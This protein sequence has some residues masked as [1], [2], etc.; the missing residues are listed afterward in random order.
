MLLHTKFP[1]FCFRFTLISQPAHHATNCAFNHRCLL[2]VSCFSRVDALEHT[3]LA[4]SNGKARVST[5]LPFS[6]GSSR[7]LVITCHQGCVIFS[8]RSQNFNLKTR[9][10]SSPYSSLT[11]LFQLSLCSFFCNIG[12]L[13][14]KVMRIYCLPRRMPMMWQEGPPEKQEGN[15][16][17]DTESADPCLP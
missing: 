15:Q 3:L 13:L 10:H 17:A 14:G 1:E 5:H 2:R 8:G 7:D 6:M 12:K 11:S 9:R 4:N 16:A